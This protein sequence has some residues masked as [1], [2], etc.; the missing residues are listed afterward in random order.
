M[1]RKTEVSLMTMKNGPAAKALADLEMPDKGASFKS[2][3]PSE[4]NRENLKE[5]GVSLRNSLFATLITVVGL[6]VAA[7]LFYELNNQTKAND[8]SMDMQG[9]VTGLTNA[10]GSNGGYPA[11]VD[12]QT[13]EQEGDFP[14]DGTPSTGNTATF[15][16]GT[17]TY[18]GNT[19]AGGNTGA[20]FNMNVTPNNAADCVSLANG[21]AGM[22]E[23]LTVGGT[24]VIKPNTTPATNAIATDCATGTAIVFY[25]G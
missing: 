13:L 21:M 12:F 3:H 19:G 18:N 25:G 1:K 2:L 23:E 4:W 5:A 14:S 6:A 22:A 17:I 16:W 11:S 7:G 24:T 20:H 8:A 10:Y 15:N 9:V